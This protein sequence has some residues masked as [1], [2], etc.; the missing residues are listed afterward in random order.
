[1]FPINVAIAEALR[2]KRKRKASEA[3]ARG[4]SGSGSGSG[5]QPLEVEP[6]L[7][8]QLKAAV[9]GGGGGGGGGGD[10]DGE[11]SGEQRQCLLQELNRQLVLELGSPSG[12]TR[13]KALQLLDVLFRRVPAFRA[14]ACRHLRAIVSCAG[15]G[16]QLAGLG[17]S[18][19]A[20]RA[21]PKDHQQEVSAAALRMIEVW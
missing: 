6:A 15:V 9:R 17:P 1:M 19:G 2:V 4:V 20:Q 16:P 3:V 14:L 7:L 18:A 21:P 8:Q 11:Q 12:A 10:G 5:S 13:V